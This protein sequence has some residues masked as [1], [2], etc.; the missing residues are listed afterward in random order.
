VTPRAIRTRTG[1]IGLALLLSSAS[2]GVRAGELYRWVTEDGRVEIG[3]N[4]PPGTTAVPYFPGQ[5]TAPQPA[6]PARPHSNARGR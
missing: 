5:E 6:A 1:V 3:M 2:G 4:P